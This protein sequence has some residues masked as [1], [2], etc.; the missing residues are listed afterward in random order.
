MNKIEIANECIGKLTTIIQEQHFEMEEMKISN[1]KYNH[2]IKL[3]LVLNLNETQK[4]HICEV[5]DKASTE[6]EMILTYK[7]LLDE[8][9]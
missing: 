5:F 9:K 8:L 3:L 7:K 1:I 2:L 4:L 6:D